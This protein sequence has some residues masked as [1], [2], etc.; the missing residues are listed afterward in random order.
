MKNVTSP[1]YPSETPKQYQPPPYVG[2]GHVAKS[3]FQ[4]RHTEWSTQSTF[5]G[6]SSVSGRSALSN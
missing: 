6:A 4:G 5:V 2:G 3:S 1:M